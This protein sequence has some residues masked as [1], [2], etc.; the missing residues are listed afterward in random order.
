MFAYEGDFDAVKFLV[1]H[2]I[3]PNDDY[4]Y[5]TPLQYAVD[6]ASFKIV[7]YLVKKCDG[8]VDAQTGNRDSIDRYPTLALARNPKI[9]KYLIDN[10]ADN[11]IPDILAYFL[12]NY[13]IIEQVEEYTMKL[14]KEAIEKKLKE[15]SYS[16][17]DDD[18][19]SITY[20][21]EFK[22]EETAEKMYD[23]LI[24]T[25]DIEEHCDNRLGIW[26]EEIE[27]AQFQEIA[28]KYKVEFKVEYT[29]DDEFG[30]TKE[31]YTKEFE[32]E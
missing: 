4:N 18:S 5:K 32:P 1:E 20:F 27:D 29:I 25:F 24:P 15:A 28:D 12:R 19:D 8:Y 22:D 31:E 17:D 13:D 14:L 2:G 7:R 11:V 16:S 23:E 30:D 26:G 21:L 9:A 3:E 6:G 10:G